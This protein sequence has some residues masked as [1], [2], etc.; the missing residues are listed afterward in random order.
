MTTPYL[1]M[2]AADRGG[3]LRREAAAAR[4]SRSPAAAGRQPGAAPPDARPRPPLPWETLCVVDPVRLR[5]WLFARCCS[6]HP[7]T[8]RWPAS[9]VPPAR[10]PAR[11]RHHRPGSQTGLLAP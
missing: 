9:P 10:T 6:S 2:L 7:A 5:R 4:R 1:E 3:E 11:R 8:G